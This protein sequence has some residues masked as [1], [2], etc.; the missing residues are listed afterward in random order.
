[1]MYMQIKQMLLTPNKYSRPQIKLSKV[2]AV[3]V[4]YVGNPG[5]TAEGNR[6]YFESLKSGAN[7]TYASSHYIIGLQGEIVQCTPENE[8]SYCTNQ[9]NSYTIS[10]EHCHPDGTGKP[11]AQTYDSLIELVADLCK[12]YKLNPLKDIIRHYDVTGK[13]CPLWFVKNSD[14]WDN[15]KKNVQA[16]I[17]ENGEADDEMVGTMKVGGGSKGVTEIPSIIKENSNYAKVRDVINEINARLDLN[18]A[19][20]Y[21]EQTKV[22]TFTK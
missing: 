14:E 11:T 4:H 2:T 13:M 6:N 22:V 18:I 5:S 16:K 1:M 12:R 9:A 8:Q 3:A 19:I 15:F 7:G 21:D 20:S 10:I 17:K